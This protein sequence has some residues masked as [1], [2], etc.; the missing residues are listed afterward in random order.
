ML[1]S[2]EFKAEFNKRISKT[3]QDF[4]SL[5]KMAEIPTKVPNDEIKN[6]MMKYL[7]H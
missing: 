5:R 4:V 6:N 2:R 3:V 1:M 7:K